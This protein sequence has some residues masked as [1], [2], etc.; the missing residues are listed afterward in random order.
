MVNECMKL[1]RKKQNFPRE[2]KMC[3][4][5]RPK[6]KHNKKDDLVF[7]QRTVTWKVTLTLLRSAQRLT[8]R[9]KQHQLQIYFCTYA[10]ASLFFFF[11]FSFPQLVFW[12]LW[13]DSGQCLTSEAC[14]T[15]PRHTFRQK[16][17]KAH[18][19]VA[20]NISKGRQTQSIMAAKQTKSRVKESGHRAQRAEMTAMVYDMY[21]WCTHLLGMWI[22][23]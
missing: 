17:G 11:F 19:E 15:G 13:S 20:K 18:K 23:W 1:C 22:L 8:R 5:F 16:A 3:C 6:W 21:V 2:N 12:E 7:S 4:I 10:T 14:S 9:T